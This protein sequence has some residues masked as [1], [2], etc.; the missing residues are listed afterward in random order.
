MSVDVSKPV[1]IA[2]NLFWIGAED[3]DSSFHC[4]PYIMLD[5]DEAVLFDPG[6]MLHV[7]TVLKKIFSLCDLKQIKHVVVTHQDPDLCASIPFLERM[8]NANFKI[9]THAKA[10]VLI[11]HYGVRSEF[12]MVSRSLNDRKLILDSGRVLQF[13][14]AWFCHFPGAFVTYDIKSKV[15]LS[16]DL[17]GGL[18][19]EWSLFANETYVDAMNAFHENYIPSNQILN[20]VLAQLDELPIEIIAPQHGSIIRENINFYIDALR[21]LPCG[22]DYIIRPVLSDEEQTIETEGGYTDL[23]TAVIKREISVV[24][25]KKVMRALEKTN[26]ELNAQGKVIDDEHTFGDFERLLDALV[27]E[28]GPIALMYCRMKVQKLAAEQGLVL[29]DSLK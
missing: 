7:D 14:P 1:E 13:Y 8:S 10:A 15:L 19:K 4:N 9:V 23:I 28:L 22:M 26:V 11:K 25:E 6:S 20:L 18:S 3:P 17:F 29:P 12:Y 24:G 5:G 27:A 2:E 16:G 21:S